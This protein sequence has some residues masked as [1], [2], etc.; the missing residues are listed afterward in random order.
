M[1]KEYDLVVITTAHS[2]FDYEFVASNAK[3]VFDTK[4][5]AKNVKNRDNIELL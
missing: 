4:N 2:N 5:A 1:L 3:W